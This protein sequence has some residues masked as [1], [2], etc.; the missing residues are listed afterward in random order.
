MIRFIVTAISRTVGV[1]M[2]LFI[3]A[4]AYGDLKAK[5]CSRRDAVFYKVMIAISI[6]GILALNGVRA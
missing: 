3:M 1:M 5:G 4:G 2:L 6:I